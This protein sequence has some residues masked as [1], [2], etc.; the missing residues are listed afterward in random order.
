M[1][2][3][4]QI[5]PSVS[6]G[7]AIGNEMIVIRDI[8]R[9]L[10][11]R[12]DIYAQ[13]IDP[14]MK[15]ILPYEKYKNSSD[16][17]NIL[18]IHYSI[19]YGDKL[20]DFVKS[21]P[22][23]KLMIYHNITPP[24]FFHGINPEYERLTKAG[25][26]ELASI[27]GI[28][29]L[30]LGDSEYNRKELN[31][32]GYRNTGV[33][34]IVI[35]FEKYNTPADDIIVKKYDDDYTNILFVGRV[36]PNKKFEDVIKS[37]YYYKKYI[38]QKSRLFM[39][40]SS[41]GMDKYSN[42]LKL[43]V[44]KLGINDV[45]FIGHIKFEELMAYY[46][47]ADAFLCMSEHEGFCVPLIECM[48]FK[49]PIIAYNSSAIPY[50][51]G[52][53]GILVDD[54][55]HKEIAELINLV[56]EDKTIRDSLINNQSIRLESFNKEHTKSIL[57]GYIDQVISNRYIINIQIEGTF[58]DS[59]SLSIINRNLALALDNMGYDV[60][61]YPTTGTGDYTPDL[62]LL[63]DHKVKELWKKNFQY[64]EF[65]IR[66]YLPADH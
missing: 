35:D 20:L 9:G 51:L 13:F 34:P 12:S 65:S 64:P 17:N 45:Y 37:F 18:I 50:T 32:L 40:G 11:Y 48:Y 8:L 41:T 4:H 22:D 27:R 59:Y 60:S 47:L 52:D 1:I 14:K 3:I 2:E 46:K 66:E 38:N 63:T 24:E 19:G 6:Y 15:D 57:T 44:D 21:L 16:P 39:V 55:D 25:R 10:G 61:L 43:L 31:S 28:I 53:S 5:H 62:R 36:S 58:E 33:L 49:I 29:D 56:V 54:K 26:I 30:A 7:D 42:Y 23:K